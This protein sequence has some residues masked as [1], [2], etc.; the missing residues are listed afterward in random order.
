[1]RS[2][3]HAAHPANSHSADLP[4]LAGSLTVP[5]ARWG[6]GARPALPSATARL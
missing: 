1:M 6:R 5:A 3:A 4:A 2:Q